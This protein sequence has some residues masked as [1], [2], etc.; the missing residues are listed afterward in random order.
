[1]EQASVAD[2][3]PQGSDELTWTREGR[4][5]VTYSDIGVEETFRRR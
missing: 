4:I 2:P 5:D 3:W 1:L